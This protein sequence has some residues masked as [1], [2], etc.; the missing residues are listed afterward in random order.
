MDYKESFDIYKN[1]KERHSK[2]FDK[3]SDEV[4]NHVK[5]I[6][7]GSIE[8]DKA[9]IDFYTNKICEYILP[10]DIEPKVYDFARN[11]IEELVTSLFNTYLKK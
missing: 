10:D 6:Y 7:E 9:N 4:F 5:K 2:S 11:G 1:K 8:G 3:N